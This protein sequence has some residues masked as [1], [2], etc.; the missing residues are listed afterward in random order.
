M[1]A[2][3]GAQVYQLALG[4]GLNPAAAVVATA[5]A[6]AE[7]GWNPTALGDVG[8][9]DDS[10]GPSVGLWQ[11]RSLKAQK[12]TGQPRDETRLADPTFNAASMANISG[13][14]RNFGAWTTYTSNAYKQYLVRSAT[15]AGQPA[16]PL[17]DGA[18]SSGNSGGAATGQNAG[19][20]SSAL[21]L[22]DLMS[23]ALKGI[24]VLTG[25]VLV[26]LGI[27]RLSAANGGPNPLRGLGDLAH[28]AGQ[29][30]AV[31]AIA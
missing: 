20:V 29:A 8:L 16:A 12:S 5:I 21:G 30:A 26:V 31:G 28:Q 23:L 10:W 6:Y 22:P 15:A 3:S 19:L 27:N 18:A 24:G 25:A 11:I 2:L 14:G 4:A 1:T 7:S 13:T 9:E 17:P